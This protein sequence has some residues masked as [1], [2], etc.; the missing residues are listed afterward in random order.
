VIEVVQQ[1]RLRGKYRPLP[2]RRVEILCKSY[3]SAERTVSSTQSFIENKLS[4]RV[5][6]EKTTVLPVTQVKFLGYAFYKK[7]GQ[8]RLRVHPT[9]WSKMKIRIKGLTSRSNGKGYAWRKESLRYYVRGW[10]N[11]FKLA[12]MWKMLA[13]LDQWYRRRLRMVIWKQWKRVKTR[14][15]NLQRLGIPRQRAWEYA[16][17][18]KG[19]WHTANS[20]ILSKTITNE[21]L[22]RAGYIFFDDYYKTIV[23]LN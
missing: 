7:D 8:I 13:R 23:P 5:N 22:K 12:D 17:T 9:S 11:Y 16:N 14:F 1:A 20:W 15:A 21:R 19:Y 2:V 3:R 6:K 10:L 4:L 18:R